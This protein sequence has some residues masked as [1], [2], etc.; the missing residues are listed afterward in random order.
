MKEHRIS[1]ESLRANLRVMRDTAAAKP[2]TSTGRKNQVAHAERLISGI[3]LA[4][5]AQPNVPLFNDGLDHSKPAKD[6]FK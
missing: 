6:L 5:A 1:L 2:L 4:L 3:D